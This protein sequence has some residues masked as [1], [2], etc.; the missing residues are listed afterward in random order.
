MSHVSV[1]NNKSSNH[2]SIYFTG[3]WT[4]ERKIGILWR[5]FHFSIRCTHHTTPN[6]CLQHVGNVMT[7]WMLTKKL[8]SPVPCDSDQCRMIEKKTKKW[9]FLHESTENAK[10]RGVRWGGALW[11]SMPNIWNTFHLIR[12]DVQRCRLKDHS[13][14]TCTHTNSCIFRDHFLSVILC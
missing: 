13:V 3:D 14:I 11:W 5:Q 4:S 6:L 9:T 1:V 7:D 10:I 8:L 12:H 2:L